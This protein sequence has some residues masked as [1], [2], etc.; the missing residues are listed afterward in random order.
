M[1]EFKD[2]IWEGIY[3]DFS[4][5]LKQ[6]KGFEGRATEDLYLAGERGLRLRDC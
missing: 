4:E 1:K 6:G 2:P 3:K 5:A